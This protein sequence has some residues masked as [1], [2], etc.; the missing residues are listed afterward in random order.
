[1]GS[2]SSAVVSAFTD[3]FLME[4]DKSLA[5]ADLA[6]AD[7]YPGDPGTRQPV[8]TVYVAASDADAGTARQWGSLARELLDEHAPLDVVADVTGLGSGLD[9]E[10]YER[11]R[12]KLATQPV[13][14]VR[15]D[16]EDGYGNRPDAEEDAD[17]RRAATVLREL[18]T[19]PVDRRL[20]ASGSRVWSRRP[21]AVGCAPWTSLSP[22]CSARTVTCRRDS[23]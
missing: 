21:A 10:V 17:A 9:A 14:D 5:G 1:M 16:F 18:L 23:W 13:E 20:P 3:D 4:L 19:F 8:H 2:A 15:L 11:V 6:L 7:H 12:N 22:A